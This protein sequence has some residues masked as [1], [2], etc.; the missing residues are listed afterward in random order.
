MKQKSARIKKIMAVFCLSLIHIQMCIRDSVYTGKLKV[1]KVDEYGNTL[2]D[3][4]F[5]ITS[6]AT[7][8][9]V[10]KITTKANGIGISKDCLLYTSRCV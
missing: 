3:A 4:T 2:A 5:E 9:V 7:N 6:D 1:I 8:E 10:D